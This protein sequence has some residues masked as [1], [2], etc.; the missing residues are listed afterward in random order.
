MQPWFDKIK[1]KYDHKMSYLVNSSV[2]AQNDTERV[3]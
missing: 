3:I 1:K 2:S